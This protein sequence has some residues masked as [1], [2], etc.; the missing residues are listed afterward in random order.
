MARKKPRSPKD[1]TREDIIRALI[2]THQRQ[3]GEPTREREAKAAYGF[4]RQ[5]LAAGMGAHNGVL[6]ARV[7]APLHHPDLRFEQTAREIAASIEANAPPPSEAIKLT[8]VEKQLNPI[9]HRAAWWHM[10]QNAVR[11]TGHI[12]SVNFS[13]GGRA[14]EPSRKLAIQPRAEMERRAFVAVSKAMPEAFLEFMDGLALMHHPEMNS[15]QAQPS[16]VDL[17]F[18]RGFD[19]Q[20]NRRMEAYATGYLKAVCD[21][22]EHNRDTYQRLVER[23]RKT[24]E[25]DESDA[26]RRRV[27]GMA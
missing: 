16:L 10:E 2:P 8:P 26:R 5:Q 12:S 24:A 4:E 7:R 3:L 9:E 15:E 11:E 19:S 20:D 22:I 23:K 21:S 25:L 18:Q 6:S 17:A 14:G 13:G 27:L 1:I